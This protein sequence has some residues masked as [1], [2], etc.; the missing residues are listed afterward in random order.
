MSTHRSVGTAKILNLGKDSIEI[1]IIGDT[2][3]GS[4]FT[5]SSYFFAVKKWLEEKP[6]RYAIHTGDLYEA[7]TIGSKGDPYHCLP[8]DQAEDDAVRWLESLGDKLIC[9][10]DGN[11]DQRYARMIGKDVVAD[12]ACK[13]G[14]PYYGDEAYLQLKIGGWKHKSKDKRTPICYSL[15]VTHGVGGGRTAGSQ[16]N[17]LLRL[18][19]IVE[20]DIYIQGHQ[21]DP[22][23]KH[24]SIY[25]FGQHG[26][27][28]ERQQ[29]FIVG[30]SAL[31]RKGYPT[32]K[33]YAP[34]SHDFPVITLS[35]DYKAMRTEVI[36]LTYAL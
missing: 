33:A 22:I 32:Q 31:G 9:M 25:Q 1:I 29:V 11:H 6:N 20:S 28:V 18:R 3:I 19:E 30:G 17:A 21:H 5:M 26:S 34:T 12:A 23:C 13:A 14:V 35:G 8:L 4:P 7:A 36:P 24:K 2:H 15:Y 10:V 16:I 27:I